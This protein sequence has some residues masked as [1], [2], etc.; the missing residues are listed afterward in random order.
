MTLAG[1]DIPWLGWNGSNGGDPYSPT[2]LQRCAV[3]AL[4][5]RSLRS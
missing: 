4:G 1:A 2:P 3:T 5:C